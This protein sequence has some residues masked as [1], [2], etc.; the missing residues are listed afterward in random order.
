MSKVTEDFAAVLGGLRVTGKHQGWKSFRQAFKS[1]W[2]KD[3]ISMISDKL[4]SIQ[5]QVSIHLLVVIR[6]A[7]GHCPVGEVHG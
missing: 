2:S 5:G 4:Q 1:I 6:S 7:V 3:Q